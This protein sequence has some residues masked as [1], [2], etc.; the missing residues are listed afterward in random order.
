MSFYA[1][2][3]ADVYHE[4]SPRARKPHVCCA[5]LEVIPPGIRYTK[6]SIVADGSVSTYKRCARCQDMHLHLREL[7]RSEE[8]MWPEERLDCGMDYKEEWGVEPPIEIAA[9]A[10]LLPGEDVSV[11]IGG[12][13]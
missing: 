6:V 2:D 12:A 5:C 1:D 8:S 9:L 11:L 4:D 3:M 13:E 10:F 7:C